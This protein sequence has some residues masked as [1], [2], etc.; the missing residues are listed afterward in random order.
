[1]LRLLLYA[2]AVAGDVGVDGESDKADT[3]DVRTDGT[4]C[5]TGSC[6]C[7]RDMWCGS[8]FFNEGWWKE[9]GS[10][11]RSNMALDDECLSVRI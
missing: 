9:I 5:S 4:D 11:S 7:A 10:I 2:P 1:M 3:A 8:A 6:A